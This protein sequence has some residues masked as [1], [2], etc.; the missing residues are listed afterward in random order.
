MILRC[1]NFGLRM[2]HSYTYLTYNHVVHWFFVFA[3]SNLI[4][5]ALLI[6]LA[7]AR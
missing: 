5:V 4:V 3:T 1:V 6:Y 7:M 2:V